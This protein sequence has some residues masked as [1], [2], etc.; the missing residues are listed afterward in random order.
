VGV[1]L[2]RAA[3][4]GSGQRQRGLS[5]ASAAV[6]CALLGSVISTAVSNGVSTLKASGICRK[7][8]FERDD[9]Q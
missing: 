5:A 2:R 9:T 3:L 8:H 1:V 6:C 4:R 7:L